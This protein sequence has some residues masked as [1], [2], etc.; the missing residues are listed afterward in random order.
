MT[1]GRDE[2]T[3]KPVA[4]TGFLVGFDMDSIKLVAETSTHRNQKEI[5]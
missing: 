5:R 1:S 4:T 3:K 2:K